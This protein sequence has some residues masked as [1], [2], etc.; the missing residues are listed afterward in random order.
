LVG[1]DGLF[2][3][4]FVPSDGAGPEV[5]ARGAVPSVAADGSPAVFRR[6]VETGNRLEI[7][8]WIQAE[9]PTSCPEL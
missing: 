6:E 2:V 5:V 3:V 8:S 1:A 4:R 7:S 9:N